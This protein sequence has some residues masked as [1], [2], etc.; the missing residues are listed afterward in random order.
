MDD[1]AEMAYADER[2]TL[3]NNLRGEIRKL[4]GYVDRATPEILQFW[5]EMRRRDQY[6]YVEQLE[7]LETLLRT[8]ESCT[9][10]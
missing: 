5:E 4:Q 6:T 9:A 8:V 1:L 10:R 3:L 2:V 7:A